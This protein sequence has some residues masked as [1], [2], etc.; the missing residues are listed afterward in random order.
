MTIRRC[1]AFLMQ[2]ALAIE[3]RNTDPVA[4]TQHCAVL[5][6]LRAITWCAFLQQYA[7]HGETLF[8]ELLYH[9][10]NAITLPI[11][12]LGWRSKRLKPKLKQVYLHILSDKHGAITNTAKERHYFD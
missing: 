10:C 9:L 5:H 2:H 3:L 1:V 4:K 7:V 8:V 11:P 12:V 6:D